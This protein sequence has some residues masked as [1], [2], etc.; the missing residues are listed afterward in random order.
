MIVSYWT[1]IQ[2]VDPR[3]TFHTNHWVY[4]QKRWKK[5]NLS[6]SVISVT[7]I[8]KLF[9]SCKCS[10]W[11]RIK[12][13]FWINEWVSCEVYL[14]DFRINYVRRLHAVLKSLWIIWNQAHDQNCIIWFDGSVK[15]YHVALFFNI[16]FS[17]GKIDGNWRFVFVIFSKGIT[18][19]LVGSN[20][21]N[22]HRHP[23]QL[24]FTFRWKANI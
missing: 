6:T 18:I 13:K 8:R 16:W 1:E 19:V 4:D 23:L 17:R 7:I 3:D 2:S 9:F 5:A 20:M 21:Q 22:N 10:F 12:C 15:K 14:W 11:E 24:F